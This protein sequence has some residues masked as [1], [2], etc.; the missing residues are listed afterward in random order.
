MRALCV[1]EW[2]RAPLLPALLSNCL[3]SH[4]RCTADGYKL[5]ARLLWN[6]GASSSDWVPCSIS[7]RVSSFSEVR[8]WSPRVVRAYFL[9]PANFQPKFGNSRQGLFSWSWP[10]SLVT[11]P[12]SVIHKS[13]DGV[14]IL[15]VC[16]ARSSFYDFK[17]AVLSFSFCN[18]FW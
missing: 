3:V 18:L 17:I 11:V 10:L 6:I 12:F 1:Y 4:Q 16:L 5:V 7:I 9:P 8:T 2:L 15:S 13:I 14:G